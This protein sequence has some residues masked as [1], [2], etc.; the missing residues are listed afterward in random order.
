MSVDELFELEPELYDSIF[1][2]HDMTYDV[3]DIKKYVKNNPYGIILGLFETI[4][5]LEKKLGWR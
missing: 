2:P 3:E 4:N 1:D 5:E